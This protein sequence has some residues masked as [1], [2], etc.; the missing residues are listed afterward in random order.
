MKENFLQR[1]SRLKRDPPT[2]E[3]SPA[4]SAASGV[5]PGAPAAPALPAP[6]SLEFSS[7]FTGFMADEVEDGL[8]RVALQKLFHAEH[9]NVMDGLDV[10]ID[11]YN[12]FEPIGEELLKNLNQAR[13]LLFDDQTPVLE[14][15][16]EIPEE[17]DSPCVE[18]DLPDEPPAS[19]DK[20]MDKDQ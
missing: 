6:D 16:E 10:Y 5:A 19:K 9:F 14:A 13:G 15:A 12:S 7:D 20:S 17:T 1:W 8:R 2:A 18:T 3:L 11:D 4:P